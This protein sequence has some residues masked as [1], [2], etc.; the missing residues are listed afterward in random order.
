MTKPKKGNG[1]ISLAVAGAVHWAMLPEALDQLV[2]QLESWTPESIQAAL[3]E[4][5]A[6]GMYSTRDGVATI[7]VQGPMFHHPNWLTSYF[8]LTTYD[9]VGLAF[10]AVLQDP[11]VRAIMLHLDTPGGMANGT[12]ELANMIYQA[13]GVKPVVAYVSGLGASAGYWVASA[14]D[15]VVADR[16]AML[17]SIGTAVTIVDTKGL[18]QKLGVKVID[19]AS[20]LSPKKRLDPTEDEG[21]AAILKTLDS[22]TAV[23]VNA[24]AA[25]RDVTPDT[26]LS[27]FGQGGVFVGQEAVDAG[28]AD[29]IGSYE[30][31]HAELRDRGAGLRTFVRPGARA[32]TSS[33]ETIMEKQTP[34]SPA[35]PGASA[36]A[37]PA[38]AT[39]ESQSEPAAQDP[40]AAAPAAKTTDEI[41][42][43][44]AAAERQRIAEIRALGRV[45]EEDVVQACID[46]PNCTPA[47]A[48]LRLRGA[49][50]QAG[51]DRL[52]SI[53]QDEVRGAAPGAAHAPSDPTPKAAARQAVG[54]YYALTTRK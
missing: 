33:S 43:E 6:G 13:R 32:I 15:E 22:L 37:D 5:A 9:D 25:H 45:G 19:M 1:L 14:A 34:K 10:N 28:L 29:R 17:G 24:V 30:S 48:A 8:D 4:P 51:R 50:M 53:K 21:R 47:A 20:T 18:Q 31:V 38:P 35:D 3:G 7:D 36:A 49:E 44:A 12:G 54:K 11:H 26:V 52:Q 23:F 2:Q 27:D 16:S 41:R 46:D 39:P 40:A 42:A